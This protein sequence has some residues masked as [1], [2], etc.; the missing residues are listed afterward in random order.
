VPAIETLRIIYLGQG[1]EVLDIGQYAGTATSVIMP[2]RMIVA[3]A[4]R[5]DSRALV[6]SHNHPSG[7]P[8]PSRADVSVT[9]QLARLLHTLDIRLHDHVIIGDGRSVSF[10]T[11]G[12]L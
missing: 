10:R 3:D 6:L 12:L 7:D 9:R 8:T 4:L 2:F 5:L 11:L 1:R